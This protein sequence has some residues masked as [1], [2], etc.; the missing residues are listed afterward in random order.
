MTF[1]R[2]SNIFNDFVV[3][4]L[5]E[6]VILHKKIG[7]LFQKL[8]NNQIQSGSLAAIFSQDKQHISVLN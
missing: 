7:I 4:Y 3:F 8:E 6:N 2:K 1:K 5:V